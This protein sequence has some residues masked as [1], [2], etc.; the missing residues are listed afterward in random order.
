MSRRPVTTWSRLR[1]LQPAKRVS[2]DHGSGKH[3][4]GRHGSGG[5]SSRHGSGSSG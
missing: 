5:G 2:H 1:P 3:G 4:S